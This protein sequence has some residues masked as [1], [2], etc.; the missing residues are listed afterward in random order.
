M[1]SNDFAA[2]GTLFILLSL[3]MIALGVVG[4]RGMF[5]GKQPGRVWQPAL[6]WTLWGIGNALYGIGHLMRH[7]G[8]ESTPV[9]ERIG[10]IFVAVSALM[11]L[12]HQWRRRRHAR[13]NKSTPAVGG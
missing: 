13:Y 6:S 5:S 7:S 8:S 4:L 9:L 1:T 11:M 3:P 10:T 2:G 12:V